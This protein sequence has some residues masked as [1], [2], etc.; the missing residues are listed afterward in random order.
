MLTKHDLRVRHVA[1]TGFR[2]TPQLLRHVGACFRLPGSDCQRQAPGW[3]AAS[4]G[5]SPEGLGRRFPVSGWRW[6]GPGGPGSRLPGLWC[7]K[8]GAAMRYVAQD[9]GQEGSGVLGQ[10]AE[11]LTA[12]S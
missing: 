1:Q 12:Q 8:P 11:A 7:W 2:A 5:V 9:E 10:A 6:Q 4:G 3:P